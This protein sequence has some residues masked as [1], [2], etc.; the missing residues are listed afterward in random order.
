MTLAI[1]TKRPI[2]RRVIECESAPKCTVFRVLLP[3]QDKQQ[4]ET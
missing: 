1:R 2:G 4:R 3:L